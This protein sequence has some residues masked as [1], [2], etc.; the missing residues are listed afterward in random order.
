MLTEP[1]DQDSLDREGRKRLRS[2]LVRFQQP[3]TSRALWQLFN[4][5]VPYALLWVS[6]YHLKEISLWLAIPVAMVL[7][8][9]RVFLTGFLVFYVDPRLGDGLMHYTEGWTLFV[10]A[11]GIIGAAAWGLTRLE[12]SRREAAA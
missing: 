9:L 11:F 10:V 1:P 7:N 8:G 3:S 6:M 4:T 2:V 5:L 12:A